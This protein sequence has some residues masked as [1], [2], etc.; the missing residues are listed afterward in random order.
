MSPQQQIKALIDNIIEFRGQSAVKSSVKQYDEALSLSILKQHYRQNHM[1]A[2][3][4]KVE[5]FT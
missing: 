1:L 3:A 4:S 2:T 5:H